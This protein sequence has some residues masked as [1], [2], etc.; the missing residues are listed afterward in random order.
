MVTRASAPRVTTPR[1]IRVLQTSPPSSGSIMIRLA[2]ALLLVTV[3]VSC[4]DTVATVGPPTTVGTNGTL[5]TS[6]ATGPGVESETL[7]SLLPPIPER[8]PFSREHPPSFGDYEE[9]VFDTVE[10]IETLGLDVLGPG[11][12]SD[13]EFP[14]RQFLPGVPASQLYMWAVGDPQP[15]SR[16]APRAADEFCR[17][18]YLADIEAIYLNPDESEIRVWYREFRDCLERKRIDGVDTTPDEQ[19]VDLSWPIEC[20]P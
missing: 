12:A 4:A 13:P 20:L 15:G 17:D 16:M 10:C 1:E 18:R 7:E 2:S 11:L 9:A 19:L 5:P 14:L 6:D 3:T 8:T